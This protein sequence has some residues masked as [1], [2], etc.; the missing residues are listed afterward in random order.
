M[1]NP[2]V[3]EEDNAGSTRRSS[4]EQP[5][6]PA[7]TRA[8]SRAAQPVN[9]I[10]RPSRHP[11]FV[12]VIAVLGALLVTA[13]GFA[14]RSHAIDLAWAQALNTLHT[15]VVGTLSSLV[16]RGLEPVAAI[17]LTILATGLIWLSTRQLR[18][19]AAFAGMVALTWIPS[20]LVKIVVARPRPEGAVLSHAF[21]PAQVDASYPSGHTV[22]ITAFVIA[23]LFVLRGTR[24]MPVGV[25]LGV[26][27]VFGVATAVTIDAVHY[28][29]DVMASIV[30]GVT[31]APGAR[32]VWVDWLMPRIPGL[33]PRPA[34][35]A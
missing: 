23:L 16:Y 31:V 13:V 4:Y 12:V 7:A 2:S 1:S 27:A 32:V 33:R 11:V 30:W 25:V 10:L 22:F 21:L 20:D 9:G 28:P 26:I 18:V 17:A 8:G 15:G 5:A 34:V 29:T 6:A 35:G 14:L 19:A 24:W 3:R